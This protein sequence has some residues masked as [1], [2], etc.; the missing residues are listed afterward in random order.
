ME[1]DQN[2]V[3]RQGVLLKDLKL[4]VGLGPLSNFLHFSRQVT[5]IG[6]HASTKGNTLCILKALIPTII[7][8][9]QVGS[10]HDKKSQRRVT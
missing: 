8:T 4:V 2:S 10:K 9:K 1:V 5:A 3:E 6:V 7:D